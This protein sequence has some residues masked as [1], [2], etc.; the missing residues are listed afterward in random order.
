MSLPIST[1]ERMNS[2]PVDPSPMFSRFSPLFVTHPTSHEANVMGAMPQYT[3]V[4]TSDEVSDN[5][6]LDDE[7]T[8]VFLAEE[9]T[10][11]STI[12]R[13]C[14]SLPRLKPIELPDVSCDIQYEY[15]KLAPLDM[16]LVALLEP[17]SHN[18]ANSA[19][20]DYSDILYPPI[21]K[22]HLP[23]LHSD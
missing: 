8:L 23:E 3:D 5:A 9:E 17:T 7:E 4:D 1:S 18:D 11:T 14:P 10:D 21:V 20:S 15:P 6:G 2:W 13:G 16:C 22:S 19:S 12:P